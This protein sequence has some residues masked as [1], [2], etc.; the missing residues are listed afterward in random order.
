MNRIS[1]IV[2][3]L[4]HHLYK[5]K[6][7]VA[8]VTCRIKSPDM[9]N[10]D[11]PP[12]LET[13]SDPLDP[14]CHWREGCPA[15]ATHTMIYQ[16]VIVLRYLLSYLLSQNT[17]LRTDWLYKY[18]LMQLLFLHVTHPTV[19]PPTTFC[20]HPFPSKTVRSQPLV[21]HLNVS[22]PPDSLG[23]VD[24]TAWKQLWSVSFLVYTCN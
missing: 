10:L 11:L 18:T 24:T 2:Y 3:S 13:D 22:P 17:I 6:T 7:V 15:S 14:W 1:S 9:F 20:P 8:V 21:D 4:Y 23:K 5:N 16:G 19:F 12:W